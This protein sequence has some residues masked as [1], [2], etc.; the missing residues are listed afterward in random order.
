MGQNCGGDA[1]LL[2]GNDRVFILDLL[3]CQSDPQIEETYESVDS[4]LV[5]SVKCIKVSIL[6][7]YFPILIQ[8]LKIRCIIMDS[9]RFGYVKVACGQVS[10][11]CLFI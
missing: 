1:F 3:S 9:E 2:H 11:L 10:I 8:N 6:P 5:I 7:F 4:M